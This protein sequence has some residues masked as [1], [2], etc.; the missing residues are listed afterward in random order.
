MTASPVVVAY[1]GHA[2]EIQPVA[3]ASP[4]DFVRRGSS[5]TGPARESEHAPHT[6]SE[7]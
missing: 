7:A 2:R 4:F 5:P 3:R 6:G 1:R